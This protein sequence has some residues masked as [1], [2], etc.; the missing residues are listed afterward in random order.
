[1]N[2]H[3]YQAKELLK[4]CDVA[5]DAGFMAQSAGDVEKR[6]GEVHGPPW[7]IKAQVHS[8]G[9]GKAGGIKL[10]RD[11]AEAFG[12]A[13]QILGMTLVTAQTGAKGRIVRKILV[14][15][16]AK[17]DKE[18][19]LSLLIDRAA[20]SYVFVGSTEG[21][22]EIEKV[23]AETPDAIARVYVDPLSGFRTYHAAEMARKLGFSGDLPAGCSLSSPKRMFGSAQAGPLASIGL[24]KQLSAIMAGMFKLFVEKDASLVEINPLVK[25]K[26]GK[27]LA[28][29]AKVNFDD[30][31]L[32][33]HPDIAAL[34][35]VGEEDPNEA[36]ASKH[37]LSYIKLDGTI[38]CLVNGAGLAMATM[39]IVK[40][41]GGSPANFLDVGG[42]ASIEKVTE[43]FKIILSDSAVKGILVNI[44][45]G[46][47]KCDVIAEGIV[48]ASKTLGVKV[49]IVAR[50]DGTNVEQG[51]RILADS[52]LNIIP[53]GSLAEAAELIVKE[54]GR[55]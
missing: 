36:Q 12:F 3:E 4:T 54:A 22:V 17:V 18:Y 28:I 47:M 44:F 34:R 19:Y 20:A 30:N 21:G 42:S 45:G 50:L 7:V 6:L 48:A 16:A 2:I 37:D 41:Y 33:R 55:F 1:M 31:G 53:A 13:N 51:K 23:A 11:Q 32:A 26:E 10:A 25:T 29:D 27:L 39:D 8:G 38:G 52:G 43:A 5:T 24:A 40:H 46:I 15:E 35:D 9:R 14:A 49:P